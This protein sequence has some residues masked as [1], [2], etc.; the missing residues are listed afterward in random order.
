MEQEKKHTKAYTTLVSD[1]FGNTKEKGTYELPFRRWLVREIESGQL[2]MAEAVTRFNFNPANGQSLISSWRKR[3]TP[4]VG[5]H[6]PDMTEKERQQLIALQ[7]R[8]KLLEKQLEDAQMKAIAMDTLV[9][10]AEE[11]LKISIRK[12]AGTK[13]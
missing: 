7:A 12:K 8:V 13:Q 4:L 1:S 3:Y 9:D 6:L 10:V 2:S 5:L 11:N